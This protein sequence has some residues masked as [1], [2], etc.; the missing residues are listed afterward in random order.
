MLAL[1]MVLKVLTEGE[2]RLCV[3]MGW[4]RCMVVCG[5]GDWVGAGEMLEEV[6]RV[7]EWL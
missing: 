6:V 2:R 1:E 5:G 4:A 3:A 7:R